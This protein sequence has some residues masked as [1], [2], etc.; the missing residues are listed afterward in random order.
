MLVYIGGALNAKCGKPK[1]GGFIEDLYKGMR[2]SCIKV[3][4]LKRERVHV[5]AE[6]YFKF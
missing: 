3:R 4:R 2:T 1:A 6:R 5:L